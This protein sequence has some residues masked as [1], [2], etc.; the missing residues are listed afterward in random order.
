MGLRMSPGSVVSQLDAMN[1]EMNRV[2]DNAYRVLHNIVGLNN[3][4]DVLCGKSYDN[5]REYFN[6]FHVVAIQGTILFAE[7]MIQA[8]NAYKGCISGQLGG[9]GYV[10]EDALKRDAKCIEEQINQVYELMGRSKVSYSAMLDS[11]YDALRLVNKKLD[12]IEGFISATGGIY[13]GAEASKE[14]LGRAVS[15]IDSSTFDNNM[16]NYRVRQI[17][18]E[19]ADKIKS[20]WIEKEIREKELYINAMKECYGFDDETSQILYD[21]YYR[22]WN[23]GVTDINQKYF[24]I[25]AS[26]V[27]GG[28]EETGIKTS[29]WKTITGPHAIESLK[30]VLGE[31]DVKTP[32]WKKIAGIYDEESLEQV[33]EGYG[34]TETEIETLY[35]K[36]KD[37]YE[38]SQEKQITDD[39]VY[40]GK[41]DL[42]HMSVICATML[43][44]N[45]TIWKF[46]GG[47]AG[48]VFNGIFNL[49]A[50]AGYVG[51]VYGTLGNGTKLTQDD[52]K[53]D[54]DAVNIFNRLEENTNLI[55]T[56]GTY[57]LEISNGDTN[58][59]REFVTNLGKGDYK[60]GVEYLHSQVI[61]NKVYL[62]FGAGA[63]LNNIG[64]EASLNIMNGGGISL[65]QD[66][67]AEKQKVQ[68]NFY[69][70]LMEGSN[71]YVEYEEVNIDLAET[72][73]TI[74]GHLSTGITKEALD[75]IRVQH[76][77]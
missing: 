41:S 23:E 27:Y 36:L 77:E 63:A 34:L 67:Y 76:S 57:Y 13:Q 37:N 22:M 26:P 58:R 19:W 65:I 49:E 55:R 39:N 74:H 68:R 60:R 16:I 14:S 12:Q 5:I 20:Q 59:A 15:C 70:S 3:T 71:E 75:S 44:D 29:I 24:A 1:G 45:E 51:D 28:K 64:V 8:N 48:W 30:Q 10:D 40:Y 53:A 52:Y 61:Q 18:R 47:A 32:A 35:K 73:K 21:L 2:I 7:E 56:M 42:S 11:L 33:L 43:K 62:S 17:D 6:L 50:N 4:T 54:L 72:G 46:A 9:I 31:I 38:K 25:L 66:V 69:R